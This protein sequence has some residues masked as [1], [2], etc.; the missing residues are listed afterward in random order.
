MALSF[1]TI[2]LQPAASPTVDTFLGLLK[3]LPKGIYS[4]GGCFSGPGRSIAVHPFVVKTADGLTIETSAIETIAVPSVISNTVYWL[5]LYSRA[6]N[7]DLGTIENGHLAEF[8]LV[9]DSEI[10]E[11]DDLEHFIKFTRFVA[12]PAATSTPILNSYIDSGVGERVDIQNRPSS[13]S[14]YSGVGNFNGQQGQIITHNVG[15]VN[16]RVSITPS[17]NPLVGLGD[18]WIEKNVNYFTVYCIGNETTQF[19]WVLILAR[20]SSGSLEEGYSSISVLGEYDVDPYEYTKIGFG[21]EVVSASALYANQI[22]GS[23]A[24]NKIIYSKKDLTT[25][26]EDSWSLLAGEVKSISAITK[27][28]PGVITSAAHG[29]STGDIVNLSGIVG[30]TQ[31]NGTVVTVTVVDANSFSIGTD[32]SSFGTYTSGGT[33]N[34]NPQISLRW[35]LLNSQTNPDVYVTD[36]VSNSATKEISLIAVTGGGTLNYRAFLVPQFNTTK[37]PIV[38]RGITSV[39]FSSLETGTYRLIIIKNASNYIHGTMSGTSSM[40]AYHDTAG[41]YVPLISF[42]ATSGNITMMSISPSDNRFTTYINTGV[43]ATAEWLIL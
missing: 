43:T 25:S 2:S 6:W 4:G 32:T 20:N 36:M 22:S 10:D 5:V 16:Y 13:Q 11:D 1:A 17:Q 27:A 28:D 42:I 39:N 31:L 29:F 3:P 38:S 33:I 35:K 41:N 19:D 15:T 12:T 34:Q 14:V 40:Q 18:I 21:G 26:A 37:K 24:A 8:R 23:P 7:P 9:L 30:M